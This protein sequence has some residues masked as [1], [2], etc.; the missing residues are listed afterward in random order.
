MFKPSIFDNAKKLQNRRRVVPRSTDL[1]DGSPNDPI[2]TA[3]I[4]ILDAAAGKPITAAA[5]NG[6]S[7]PSAQSQT[8]STT[9]LAA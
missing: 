6:T 9:S 1:Y 4:A 3:Q 8:P 5:L 7:D 2:S